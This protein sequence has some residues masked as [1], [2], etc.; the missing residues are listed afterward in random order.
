LELY[1]KAL[2]TGVGQRK[3]V[4]RECVMFESYFLEE[5]GR[6][7]IRP[8]VSTL[9]TH[10]ST[11]TADGASHWQPSRAGLGILAAMS[12]VSTHVVRRGVS[13]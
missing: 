1:G 11:S 8:Q 7:R 13:T 4:A 9:P 2:V 6:S 10:Q 3:R 12:D 5:R